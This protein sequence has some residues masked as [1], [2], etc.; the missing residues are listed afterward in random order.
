M[1]RRV[2]G[3]R[4]PKLTHEGTEAETRGGRVGVHP[5][6]FILGAAEFIG[7]TSVTVKYCTLGPVNVLHYQR[8]SQKRKSD[9]PCP[10]S[11]NLWP[12]AGR[13]SEHLQNQGFPQFVLGGVFGQG[14]SEGQTLRQGLD[15]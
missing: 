14:D 9:S 8:H 3:L 10:K 12:W 5:G 4:Q 13:A 15:S 1:V 11:Y 6:A 2:A 7:V